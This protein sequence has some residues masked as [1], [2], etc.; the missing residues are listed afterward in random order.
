MPRE[1]ETEVTLAKANSAME[2]VYCDGDRIYLGGKPGEEN[3]SASAEALVCAAEVVD[4]VG[5]EVTIDGIT[6]KPRST[7]H[8]PLYLTV[9]EGPPYKQNTNAEEL[10][11]LLELFD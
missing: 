7:A 9:A 2:S 5:G 10:R 4:E 6:V 1:I 3:A 8:N 11:A